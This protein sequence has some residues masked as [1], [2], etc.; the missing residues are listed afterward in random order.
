MAF[1]H[2]HVH[3]EFSNLDGAIRVKELAKKAKKLGMSAVAITD[4]GNMCGAVS[5][6]DAMTAEGIKPIIGCEFYVAPG[7]RF[8]KGEAAKKKKESGA[9][10]DPDKYH[11]LVLLA[12]DE[13]GYVNLCQLMLV[14]YLEGRYYKPRIDFKV[15]EQYHEGLVCLSACLAGELPR[16]IIKNAGKEDGMKE[17]MGV[18]KRYHDLFG[19]DYYMEI[20][21]HGIPEELTVAEEIIRLSAITG[22]KVVCTNDC[23]YLNSDDAEAHD[24]L[25]CIQTKHQVDDTDR[26][27][28][29]GDYSFKSE[30]EMRKLF[31]AFQE[32]FDNTMEIADKCNFSFH[33]AHGSEDYRMPRVVIPE[34]FGEDYFGY[35]KHL[36]LKGYEE[37]YPVGNKYRDEALTRLHEELDVID[38]MGFSEYFLDTWTTIMWAKKHG[39]LVGPGRGSA[40][41]SVLCYCTR[42][43]DLCPVKYGL[44]FERFLNPERATMPDI[45]VDYQYDKKDDVLAFE[46][47]RNGRDK[48]CKIQTLGTLKAKQVLKDV[49]RVAGLTVAE[50]NALS[51]LVPFDPKATL[52]KTY[53]QNPEVAVLLGKNPMYQKVWDISLKL[54][55]LKKS[56]G[57]HACGHIPTPRPASEL[58]PCGVDEKTGYLVCQYD[59]AEAEH[60]GN[61]KKDLLMLRNLTIISEAQKS[62]KERYGIDIPLW[63]DDILNDE[64]AL[65]LF[66]NGNTDGIFQFESEGMRKFMSELRPTCFED[67][68]AGVSLYRPGPMDYISD[69]IK[70]KHN[71]E[72][73]TYAFDELEPILAPTYG[74]I[75]YQ[76]QPMQIVQLLAGFSKGEADIMRKG[77]GK[78]KMDIIEAEGKKFIDGDERF[79]GCVKNGYDRDKAVALWAKMAKFGEYAFNKSHAACYAAIS[80]QTA[81]LRAH[82]PAEMFAGLLT[83]VT[84]KVNKLTSYIKAAKKAGIHIDVPDINCSG[85]DFSV[86]D[87]KTLVF[88]LSSLKGVGSELVKSIIAERENGPFTGIVEFMMR[89]P[90]AN[91]KAIEVFIKSGAFDCF[92]HSRAS[93]LAALPDI[94]KKVKKLRENKKSKDEMEGQVSLFDLFDQNGCKV[95][96]APKR[97]SKFN[98]NDWSDEIIDI[99]EYSSSVLLDGEFEATGRYIS[100]HPFDT[101]EGKVRVKDYV[102]SELSMFEPEEEEEVDDDDEIVESQVQ[103]APKSE[104]FKRKQR[105]AVAGVVKDCKMFFTKA[106]NEPMM[107]F[108]VED[109]EGTAK[110]VLFPKDYNNA[111]EMGTVPN[112]GDVVAVKGSIMIDEQDGTYSVQADS[113]IALTSC[114]KFV[115][116]CATSDEMADGWPVKIED[117]EGHDIIRVFNSDTG[118]R[119]DIPFV[120]GE[121]FLNL[122]KVIGLGYQLLYLVK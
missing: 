4:H 102:L 37:R 68:I 97:K 89:V 122:M 28:Y 48:F 87:E 121:R 33:Y 18:V 72:S 29:V 63:T 9:V 70:G 90:G 58:F 96:E 101:Y 21:N 61:L 82:Y 62:V 117:P 103:Q 73:I 91:K 27:R 55:G 69:Y 109:A 57:T 105:V 15:L 110:V 32:A 113:V 60:L 84:D 22:I 43:T 35:L 80:M 100:G 83:S 88:G 19:D 45:D 85:S 10:E 49:A 79:P 3:T 64:E 118:M 20:Q 38:R 53:E 67:I 51:K 12:K 107:V 92:G 116:A 47:E 42:I 93:M 75:V 39:I 52:A 5:F 71:P 17:V 86:K 78:K 26:L 119:Q 46:A 76:E 6:F 23:H 108:Y 13:V 120:Y 66:W 74:V 112:N 25:V 7:S 2:L 111:V 59:M 50:G 11:H 98:Y 44:L 41:G 14:S 81:Y 54:E 40:A 30:E 114:R 99:P 106:K 1:T 65:K 36:A 8:D 24:W 34:E 94:Q 77:M 16:T 115:T 95:D 104:P 31:P 56:A